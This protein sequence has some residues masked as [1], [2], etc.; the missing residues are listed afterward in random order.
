MTIIH[1]IHNSIITKKYSPPMSTVDKIYL[2]NLCNTSN[3]LF[4]ILFT[5]YISCFVYAVFNNNPPCSFGK[6]ILKIR[7][8]RGIVI[9]EV[10]CS[11]T[12]CGELTMV[13]ELSS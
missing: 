10:N 9:A 5:Q 6:N 3:V 11:H 8:I 1:Y 12:S 2:R 4:I 7:H 13:S